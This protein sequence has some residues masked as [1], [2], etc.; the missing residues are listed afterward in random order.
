M[1]AH[2]PPSEE[3]SPRILDPSF[4]DDRSILDALRSH[5]CNEVLD[6]KAA[7][8]EELRRLRPPVARHL[9]EEPGR[10]VYYPW[11][12]ALVG[13]VGPAAF[14][15]LRL[16]RNRNKITPEEQQVLASQRIGVV[17]LSVGHAIAH[18]LALEGL[19]GTLR[20]AD[21]DSVE[22]SNLN[23]I[24]ATLFDLGLNKAVVTARR[25]AELDPYL[26][27]EV[28]KDGVTG[29]SVDAF[30]NGL[31][32]VIEECDSLDVKLAV[33]E[34][35]RRHRVP[36]VMETS[37]RG[38][39]DVE[40]FDLEPD[41]PVF[42]GLLGDLRAADL[43]GLSTHDKV[44]YV[45]RILEPEHLSARMAASMAEI[46][47]TLTTWPQ[48]GGD[49]TLGGA[50]VAAA[51][52]RIGRGLALCSG[53]VRIDVD[54]TLGAISSP[55]PASSPARAAPAGPRVAADQLGLP[56]ARSRAAP[57]VDE[58][59]RAVLRAATLAPSGGNSQPW[60]F[61]PGE[62]C[63][64]I[65]VDPSRSTTMDVGLRGSFVAAGAALFNARVAAARHGV[66]GSIELVPHSKDSLHV[67][68]V[69]LGDETDEELA[70][71][72]ES[73][74]R[75]CTNRQPGRAVAIEGPQ[76][77]ALEQA[78][79]SEGARVRLYCARDTVAEIGRLL[80]E[81]DRLRYLS[82]TLHGEMMSEL[83]WPGHDSLE[84]GLDVRTLE[85]DSSD[86]AKLHVAR[87][88]D[89]MECLAAWG[90]GEALG[91]VTRDRVRSS[92]AI[93]VVT[94]PDV[95]PARYV[96][97]GSAVERLWVTAQEQGL[98]A[99]P[100]SP[101]FL[102]AL[103]ERERRTLVPSHL[104]GDLESLDAAFREVTGIPDEERYVLV[105]RLSHA[106]PPTARSQRLPLW[107]VLGSGGP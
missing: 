86:L 54:S 94:V 13:L 33:R 17:G 81:S 23:R 27:I 48:L 30:V 77:A 76:I 75:R 89:V 47:Y 10:W 5:P 32:I 73:M 49:V 83:R 39:L 104:L 36:V 26:T 34:S 50:S 59:L 74:L 64:S 29:Q 43:A 8:L 51:V 20:L 45:L 11:R 101:V 66:L 56:A 80:G 79:S 42:H 82:P 41:R 106:S 31:D 92:S 24:P 12:R 44:P 85:L 25:I 15:R 84:V 70:S 96:H 95:Q 52:R 98:S 99:Q 102:F 87:R 57:E 67:A 53:R 55:S 61:T 16:D 14:S 71:H 90:G 65:G 62:R 69:R 93:A 103:D 97:G 22:V 78:A 21:F 6:Q 91:E 2:E 60:V 46:D 37:D 9:L 1:T 7:Q 58:T 3:W 4:E 72:Y 28:I 107:A 88:S 105:L 40:R 100:V 63:F 18:T 35:A 38:L 68:T 19:C